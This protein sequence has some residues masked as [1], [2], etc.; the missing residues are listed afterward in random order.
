M[1]ILATVS[2]GKN[3]MTGAWELMQGERDSFLV[4]N[5]DEDGNPFVVRLSN[6]SVKD[7]QGLEIAQKSYL[8]TVNAADGFVLKRG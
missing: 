7:L 2:F 8:G 5:I 1:K 4:I 6:K 3:Q